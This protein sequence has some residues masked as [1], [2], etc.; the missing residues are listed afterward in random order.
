VSVLSVADAAM[1]LGMTKQGVRKAIARGTLKATLIPKG[2]NGSEY[3]ILDREIERYRTT[4]LRPG[5]RR[6]EA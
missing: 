3:A 6:V 5:H 4:H 2:R 1:A